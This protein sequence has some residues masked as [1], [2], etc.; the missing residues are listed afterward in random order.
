MQTVWKEKWTYIDIDRYYCNLL[1]T[2]D[3]K[4]VWNVIGLE[5]DLYENFV[6]KTRKM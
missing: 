1:I 5:E 4:S 3:Q 6:R 2:S